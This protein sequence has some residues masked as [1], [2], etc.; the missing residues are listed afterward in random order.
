MGFV[1]VHTGY[2]R[3]PKITRV[4]DKAK[5]LHLA[6]ILWTAEHLT[7]GYVPPDALP[8]LCQA[9]SKSPRHRLSWVAEL[10]SARLWDELPE[11][12]HVHNFETHNRS[13]TRSVVEAN[14][15]RWRE[16]QR[17]ARSD[18]TP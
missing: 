5:L 16:R 14:R 3:H 18:V 17:R 1:F 8:T 13:S 6:S 2:L 9:V 4:S 12:W 10:V 15:E 11:G 7:D